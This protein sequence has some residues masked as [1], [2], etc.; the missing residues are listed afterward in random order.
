MG[1]ADEGAKVAPAPAAT[2]V[3]L[4]IEYPEGVDDAVAMG[5]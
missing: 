5:P 4:D 2:M 3:M 1:G